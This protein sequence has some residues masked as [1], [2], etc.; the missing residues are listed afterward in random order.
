MI[1]DELLTE[2]TK[3]RN[4]L[5]T[6]KFLSC[7]LS[8]IVSLFSK[9]SVLNLDLIFLEDDVDQDFLSKAQSQIF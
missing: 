1:A 2:V 5:S 3:F 8:S 4:E 9:Y 6:L 7:N